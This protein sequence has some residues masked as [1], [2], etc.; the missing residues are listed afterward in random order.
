[1]RGF[2]PS[3]DPPVIYVRT[4]NLHSI[5]AIP[6][7]SSYSYVF[8]ARM[9]RVLC[10]RPVP[11]VFAVTRYA[12]CPECEFGEHDGSVSRAIRMLSGMEGNG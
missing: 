3:Y 11:L 12:G 5:E 4:S 1:M 6:S 7:L 2:C 8:F 10:Q 9:C